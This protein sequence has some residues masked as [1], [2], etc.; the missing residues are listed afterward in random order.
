MQKH[1]S[2]AEHNHR[3]YNC[4]CEDYRAE[5]FD[6]K[7]TTL[8]YTAL[9]WIGALSVKRGKDIGSTHE[10]IH[11]NINPRRDGAKMP[12]TVTAW[13]NYRNLYNYC[14]TARYEGFVDYDTWQ[15]IKEADHAHSVKSFNDFSKYI[16]DQD[17]EIKN[18]LLK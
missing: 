16:K 13:N 18:D 9:H 3:F 17:I 6:W 7:I 15:K 1:L 10:E 8:F 12:I 4:I 14:H 5:F 11:A 2:Q